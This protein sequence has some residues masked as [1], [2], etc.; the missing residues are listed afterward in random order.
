MHV[1]GLT[2]AA[3][4]ASG[5]V[6]YRSC[7]SDWD[8]TGV[9]NEVMIPRNDVAREI[10][11]H[12]KASIGSKTPMVDDRPLT[13]TA[14]GL[15]VHGAPPKRRT[16]S[17]VEDGAPDFSDD[18]ALPHRQGGRPDGHLHVLGTLHPPVQEGVGETRGS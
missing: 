3:S 4:D 17:A 12:F 6:D 7:S 18:L 14:G 5:R 16:N 9:P 11:N 8:W 15:T 2:T 10:F 13:V 1:F